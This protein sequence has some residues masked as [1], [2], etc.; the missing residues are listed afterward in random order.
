MKLMKKFVAEHRGGLG[1]ICGNKHT[2]SL[3][4]DNRGEE[5]GD[6]TGILPV[7]LDLDR[8]DMPGSGIGYGGYFV[9]TAVFALPAFALLGRASRWL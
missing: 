2:L 6:L 9:L 8:A 4:R 7:I 1:F 3:L 5:E